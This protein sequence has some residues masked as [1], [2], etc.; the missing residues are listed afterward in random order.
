MYYTVLMPFVLTFMGT[1]L[2]FAQCSQS[3]GEGFPLSSPPGRLAGRREEQREKAG[4]R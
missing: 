2:G 1:W 3:P 4:G